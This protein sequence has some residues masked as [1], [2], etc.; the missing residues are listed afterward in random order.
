M[1][2]VQSVNLGP[3]SEFVYIFQD[4]E[5]LEERPFNG[6]KSASLY[7]IKYLPTGE[8]KAL[9]IQKTSKENKKDLETLKKFTE[10]EGIITLEDYEVDKDFIYQILEFAPQ[11]SLADQIKN[12]ESPLLDSSEKVISLFQKVVGTLMKINESG[13]LHGD[14]KPANIVL[15]EEGEPRLIDFDLSRELDSTDHAHGSK[16]FMSPELIRVLNSFGK[17]TYTSKDEVFALGVTLYMMYKRTNPYHLTYRYKDLLLDTPV[18]FHKGDNLDIVHIIIKC[19]K[20]EDQRITLPELGRMV[21]NIKEHFYAGR[22]LD[23]DHGFLSRTGQFYSK[24]LGIPLR[25]FLLRVS[26]FGLVVVAGLYAYILSKKK[27][28]HKIY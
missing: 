16:S 6:G 11:L 26:V 5:C 4:F 27:D 15:T 22:V 18:A 8:I 13:F 3:C 9:K 12:P 23:R 24:V 10:L 19:L 25:S 1:C 21:L 28:K 2:N 14:V 20:K 17:H 7:R